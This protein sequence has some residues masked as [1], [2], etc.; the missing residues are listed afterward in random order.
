MIGSPTSLTQLSIGEPRHEAIA[1]VA[2]IRAKVASGKQLGA[3]IDEMGS[4]VRLAGITE[5][6]R[7]FSD[8]DASHAFVGATDDTAVA[9]AASD[10]GRWESS[11]NRPRSVVSAE[12]PGELHD[13]FDKPPLVFIQGDWPTVMLAPSVA[14]VGTR[15]P[16]SQGIASARA[17]TVALVKRDYVIN[18]GLAAGIDT[19]AHRA[20]LDANGRTNAVM[21]TG[22]A[23]VY[24]AENATLAKEIV[25]S[26]GALVSPFFPEQGPTRWSF[27]MRNVVMS[28]LSL[29]T[30]VIEAGETSGARMQARVAL[31]HGRT[32]FLLGSLVRSHDWARK[33]AVDGAYGTRAIEINSPDD[34]LDRLSSSSTY[35]FQLA[36]A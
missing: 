28:A 23:H 32:V 22:L 13:I 30:I 33:L 1:T 7:L 35:G 11:G 3:I 15:K 9:L 29:A 26:G 8:P 20:A 18:S 14:V 17:V 19:V 21:G 24:P 34:V 27:P 31:R 25:E 36:V 2:L 16:S 6:S 4:A 12:Y 5:D 10:I